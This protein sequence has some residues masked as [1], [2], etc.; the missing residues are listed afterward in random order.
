MADTRFLLFLLR[1]LSRQK[2]LSR[3]F[4]FLLYGAVCSFFTGTLLI[5]IFRW[6]A[7]ETTVLCI[8]VFLIPLLSAIYGLLGLENE[9]ELLLKADNHYNLPETLSS[10]WEIS[11]RDPDN[12]FFP[13]LIEDARAAAGKIRQK[14]VYPFVF[15]QW[16][17]IVPVL[18]ASMLFL[19]TFSFPFLAV[20]PLIASEGLIL[21]ELGKKLAE[22]IPEEDV[23]THDLAL[24]L[25]RLGEKLQEKPMTRERARQ[26][27]DSFSE[28]IESRIG[29]LKRQNLMAEVEEDVPGAKDFQ[30]DIFRLERGE[31]SDEGIAAFREKIVGSDEIDPETLERIEKAFDE[32]DP[33]SGDRGDS[34]LSDKLKEELGEQGKSDRTIDNLSSAEDILSDTEDRLDEGSSDSIA[35]SDNKESEETGISSG[36]SRPGEEEIDEEGLP[37]EG[38]SAGKSSSAP[39]GGE[40]EEPEETTEP[41]SMFSEGS[42]KE[43]EGKLTPG[44]QMKAFI[45]SLPSYSETAGGGSGYILEYRKQIENVISTEQIPEKYMGFVRDYFLEIGVIE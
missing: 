41:I 21:E 22:E 23:E 36:T 25:Q 44:D 12:P 43:L 15:R 14:D 6:Q 16:Q 31:S 9:Q 1:D 45:R 4:R 39:G 34:W 17:I 10:A 38:G 5:F 18:A 20:D 27:V 11:K 8:G 29:D 32:Y 3:S 42:M 28:Q 26:E 33:G 40:P 35:Q 7:W 24:K 37:G 30:E 19:G 13:L 2:R